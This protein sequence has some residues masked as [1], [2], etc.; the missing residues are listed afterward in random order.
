MMV[1]DRLH[2]AHVSPVKLTKIA[3]FSDFR[4]LA[5]ASNTKRLAISV[6]DLSQRS[7]SSQN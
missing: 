4:E 5:L 2:S 3:R 6:L 1:K 7:Q